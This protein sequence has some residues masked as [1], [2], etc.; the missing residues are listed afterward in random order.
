ML[1]I[2]YIQYYTYLFNIQY[3][4]NKKKIFLTHNSVIYYIIFVIVLEKYIIIFIYI[5]ENVEKVFKDIKIG[6]IVNTKQIYHYCPQLNNYRTILECKVNNKKLKFVSPTISSPCR[7]TNQNR[8]IEVSIKWTV[9]S[10]IVISKK[11]M[12]KF[13]F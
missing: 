9:K 2:Q 1:F 10:L 11:L 3:L 13:W 5:L 7:K 8:L 4:L 6:L 12:Y